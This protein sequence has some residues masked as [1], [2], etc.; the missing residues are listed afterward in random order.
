[1]RLILLLIL[2]AEK[3]GLLYVRK[4]SW[5]EG[6]LA[7]RIHTVL[8]SFASAAKFL[9]E[10]PSLDAELGLGELEISFS[11]RLNTPNKPE[12]YQVLQEPVQKALD[13]FYDGGVV[14]LEP[15][16]QDARRSLG[17]QIKVRR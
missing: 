13:D 12:S 6:D 10:E 8:A 16:K 3:A 17:F 1:M 9:R 7:K 11:D 15:L 2:Q 14:D 4:R 5:P